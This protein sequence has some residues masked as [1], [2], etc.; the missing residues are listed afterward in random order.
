MG[1]LEKLL[2]LRSELEHGGADPERLYAVECAYNFKH[3]W[4]DMARAL[5]DVRNQ[6][7]Y[8]KWGF[9]DFLNYCERELG[10]KRAVVDKLTASFYVL[11]RVAPD[12]LEAPAEDAPIP[13]CQALDYYSRATGELRLDGNPSRDA[14]E[15]ELSPE[16]SGQLYEA[17]FNQGCSPKQLRERFDPLIR[18]KPAAKEQQEVT[19]KALNS[20]RKLHELMEEVEG[21]ST[22]TLRAAYDVLSHLEEEMEVHLERLKEELAAAEEAE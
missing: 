2:V 9:T 8:E 10:L 22:E 19:R 11:E 13:S 17:V 1:N 3:S 6:N 16:L 7:S 18:P 15:E 21:L 20:A 14:P 5:V 12:R 4:L